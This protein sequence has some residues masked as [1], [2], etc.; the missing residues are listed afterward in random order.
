MFRISKIK[1][2]ILDACSTPKKFAED[3]DVTLRTMPN[4][5]LCSIINDEDYLYRKGGGTSGFMPEYLTDSVFL[6]SRKK[7]YLALYEGKLDV[8]GAIASELL[9]NLLTYL[10][11]CKRFE[12]YSTGSLSNE[13]EYVCNI[14]EVK[15]ALM[16]KGAENL[17]WSYPGAFECMKGNDFSGLER[18]VVDAPIKRK[19][20]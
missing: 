14:S 4:F 11:V 8:R 19:S 15:E 12:K 16:Q 17:K 3:L 9:T 10:T 6:Y 7:D 18:I 2:V 5:N 20:G 1:P 13:V